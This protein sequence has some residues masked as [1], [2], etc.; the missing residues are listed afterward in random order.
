MF[1]SY[2]DGVDVMI[3]TVRAQEPESA[4]VRQDV[5]LALHIIALVKGSERVPRHS[6]GAANTA[7]GPRGALASP[8]RR[9]RESAAD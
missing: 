1:L 7:C 2:R 8:R 6:R 4:P 5:R 9:D 3:D